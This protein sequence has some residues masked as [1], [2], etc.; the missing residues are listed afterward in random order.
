MQL[1]YKKYPV[2]TYS[3]YPA[4]F[5]TIDHDIL[6]IRLSSWFGIHGSVL[7]WFKSYLSS[8]FFRVKCSNSSSRK[9]KDIYSLA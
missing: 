8:R 2:S 9:T 3:T 1:D 6:I 5:D 4:T 7:N